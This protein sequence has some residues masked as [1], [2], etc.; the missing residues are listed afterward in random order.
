[1]QNMRNVDTT[2]T[3]TKKEVESLQ[4]VSG[5]WIRCGRLIPHLDVK[6]MYTNKPGEN[7][8]SSL[9]RKAID[10][11]LKKALPRTASYELW[12]HNEIIVKT[13]QENANIDLKLDSITQSVLDTEAKYKIIKAKVLNGDIEPEELSHEAVAKLKENKE[14]DVCVITPYE[15][16]SY[17]EHSLI[18]IWGKDYLSK[19][20]I[21]FALD[22]DDELNYFDTLDFSSE[23]L[24]SWFEKMST[25]YKEEPHF[26]S[27][28]VSV[29][30]QNDDQDSEMVKV[31]YT[32]SEADVIW[33]KGLEKRFQESDINQE[34]L[35]VN[36][37]LP[38]RPTDESKVIKSVNFNLPKNPMP[39]K[40]NFAKTTSNSLARTNNI[41]NLKN[42]YSLVKQTE[43]MT[44]NE[45]LLALNETYKQF[46][47]AFPMHEVTKKSSL[48]FDEED[49]TSSFFSSTIKT[50]AKIRLD[51]TW[52]EIIDL[53]KNFIEDNTKDFSI[54]QLEPLKEHE[55]IKAQVGVKFDGDEN[56]KLESP[57]LKSIID[58]FDALY[59]TEIENSDFSSGAEIAKNMSNPLEIAK[60]YDLLNNKISFDDPDRHQKLVQLRMDLNLLE[61]TKV[62]LDLG[63]SNQDSCELIA[64][65][66]NQM[67]AK[68]RK[69]ASGAFSFHS[70]SEL[71]RE[72]SNLKKEYPV[73][74]VSNNN[75]VM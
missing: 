6:N 23:E 70:E 7:P 29:I 37:K 65:L 21:N 18:K 43:A 56:N 2:Q 8:M 26:L 67:I 33:R 64:K 52:K 73:T 72:L 12:H 40:P 24:N 34:D 30:Q 39:E 14:K 62:Y 55:I 49:S 10:D 1:M 16:T 54:Q 61:K 69:K 60:A 27:G 71:S 31:I 45:N 51:N 59:L 46:Q 28:K 68:D 42:Y 41:K 17:E 63:F 38:K 11:Y 74:H 66:Q 20:D 53:L 9:G 3:S 4:G 57:I 35:N 48:L 58:K 25:I 19:M 44:F 36:T 22:F 15:V 13:L 47:E 75:L 32:E 5:N 50:T